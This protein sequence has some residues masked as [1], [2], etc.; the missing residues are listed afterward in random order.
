MTKPQARAYL[1]QF[2]G[3]M[4]ACLDRLRRRC[5]A[6]GGPVE[7]DLDFTAD[8][9]D[10][11]WSWA[12]PRFQWREG[13]TP[14]ASRG[15]LQPQFNPDDLEPP[16]DLPSWFYHPSGIGLA[17]F[18]AATLLLIDRL[19]RYLGQAVINSVPGTGWTTGATRPKGNMFANHP[20]LAGIAYEVSPM[21]ACASLAAQ[22][23][24]STAPRQSLR[25]LFDSLASQADA[26]A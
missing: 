19:G 24:W 25:G 16:E 5:A 21:S 2:L 20:V 12:A 3:E 11:V 26:D 9:L 7:S 23:E 4:P 6:T 22:P 8:S 13:Y 17:R 15:D 10:R 18:S 14:P 1:E